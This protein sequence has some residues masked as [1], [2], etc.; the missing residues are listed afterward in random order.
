MTL[1]R[2]RE[3]EALYIQHSKSSRRAKIVPPVITAFAAAATGTVTILGNNWWWPSLAAL[4]ILAMA[5]FVASSAQAC[6]KR[7]VYQLRAAAHALALA[8]ATLAYLIILFGGYAQYTCTGPLALLWVCQKALVISDV[9]AARVLLAVV[10]FNIAILLGGVALLVGDSVVFNA[11]TTNTV[12]SELHAAFELVIS[13]L[14]CSGALLWVSLRN[15]SAS[16]TVFYWNRVVGMNVESLDAE[17][18]PFHQRRLRSW[19]ARGATAQEMIN[20]NHARDDGSARMFWELDGT[21]LQLE[22]KIAAGGGGVVWKATYEGTVVAAKQ[23]YGGL[24]SG[25]DQLQEL[26]TEVGVLAQLAHVNIVRFL[27]LCRSSHHLQGEHSEYLPL[28]IVQE[29]CPTNLRAMLGN[30]LPSLS[31]AEWRSEVRRVA[32]EI[33]RAMAYLHSRNVV[34][35]DLK[36]ENVL[37]TGRNTVQVADFGISVQFFDNPQSVNTEGGTPMYMAPELLHPTYFAT[38][39]GTREHPMNEMLGDVFAY[40]VVLC[41]LVH[42]DSTVGVTSE[43]AENVVS[44]RKLATVTSDSADNVDVESQW[45]LP[46]F[47]GVADPR[48]SEL[49]R[50][51]CSF[52]PDLR[53]SFA[54]VCRH[55]L[56]WPHTT[57]PTTTDRSGQSKSRSM[58]DVNASFATPAL[59]DTSSAPSKPQLS[60]TRVNTTADFSVIKHSQVAIDTCS[61]MSWNRHRL[62]FRDDA[63]ERRFVAFL[64]SEDFFRNLRWPYVTLAALQLAFATAMFAV[65][66]RHYA[67][68]PL[69]STALFAA[70]A[71]CSLLPRLQ[72]FSMVT[73]L[74]L[75][76]LAT[77]VQCATVWSAILN[78]PNL[79]SQNGS[80]AVETLCVCDIMLPAL[81]GRTQCP[82]SCQ[83]T[84]RQ[85]VFW[86][87]QLPLLQD[88]TTPVTLLVLSL[89]FYLYVWVCALCA[90]SWAGSVAG[91]L[92]FWFRDYGTLYFS[93]FEFATLSLPGLVLFPICAIT[94]VA[95]E[96]LQRQMFLKL[97]SLRAEESHLL[98][99][100][101]FRGYRDALRANWRFLAISADTREPSRPSHVVTSATI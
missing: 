48:C 10:P 24:C 54:E 16:R 37:L 69:A 40:G 45:M 97:C 94:A 4:F 55:C 1:F 18:N 79:Q 98:E 3:V 46:P 96:R 60:A 93:L 72:R 53:L 30:V 61:C 20:L 67:L 87:Y 15:E 36:P 14:A 34:H 100:A 64:H 22:S 81:S 92:F 44:N 82:L 65:N 74:S 27:G 17:A 75:A 80:D 50:L 78:S 85:W 68:A 33:A 84:T 99:R 66:R 38:L 25:S 28:F 90:L 62:R 95:G 19:L 49:G 91:G 7:V 21:L 12:A 57:R 8:T 2:D 29:Y 56:E 26:A 76:L 86:T 39:R 32:L 70:A 101:T 47:E 5:G 43:L 59:V 63:M 11:T 51:C 73:L 83:T 35:R 41:E 58:S 9:V 31:P 77:F 6:S 71:L 52:L 89:P 13:V 42:S 88:L 23:L